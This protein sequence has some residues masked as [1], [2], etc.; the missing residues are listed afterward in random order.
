LLYYYIIVCY[1]CID[2]LPCL[3]CCHLL[4]HLR[5]NRF[6]AGLR[7]SIAPFKLRVV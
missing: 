6:G 2:V 1:H 4:L 7:R 5:G 3:E